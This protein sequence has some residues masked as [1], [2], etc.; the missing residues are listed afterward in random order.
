MFIELLVY[1]RGAVGP[2]YT[3]TSS[4]LTGRGGGREG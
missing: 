1:E 4:I 3:H 2:R